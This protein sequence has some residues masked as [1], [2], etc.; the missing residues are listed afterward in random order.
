MT[1]GRMSWNLNQN[2][3]TT[4]TKHWN[5]NWRSRGTS[6]KEHMWLPIGLPSERKFEEML[7]E[8]RWEKYQHGNVLTYTKSSVFSYQFVWMIQTWLERRRTW[9]PCG[10]LAER[11]RLWRSNAITR[12]SVFRL[13]AMT[14]KGWSP[15]G[16][17]QNRVVQEVNDGKGGWRKRSKE[18]KYSLEKIIGWSF[19]MER[20]AEKCVE[21]YCEWAQKDVFTLQQVATP[22]IDDHQIPPGDDKMNG[23]FSAVCAQM[24]LKCLSWQEL[25]DQVYCGQLIL[26]H[27]Q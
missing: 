26:W 3:S 11:H 2:S 6:W 14:G 20:P 4:K 18:R 8:R 7:F 13:R 22:C 9:T 15:S 10:N 5:K 1:E 21:N 12:S 17:V 16:S 23:E 19:D 27:N 24:V 25:D